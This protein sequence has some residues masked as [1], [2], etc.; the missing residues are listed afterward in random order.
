M[1]N[2]T[3]TQPTNQANQLERV[4]THKGRW[5]LIGLI[6][7]FLMPVALVIAMIKY[8]WRPSTISVE[9]QLITPPK[10]IQLDS[11][12]QTSDGKPFTKQVWQDHWTMLY[13]ADSCAAQCEARVKELR[14]IHVSLAQDIPRMQRV[15]VTAQAD[16][17]KLQANYPEMFILHQPMPAVESLL[18]Q[19]KVIN[20]QQDNFM[21]IVD[22]FGNAMMRYNDNIEAI[23]IR[24]DITRLLK[25][26]SAA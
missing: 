24:K 4:N 22:P 23:K 18:T 16:I 7:F 26:A 12:L 11:N 2:N 17:S 3:H 20:Q 25:F 9:G 5:V 8:D 14:Q 15:L 6:V 19:L 1:D 10:L 21:V 13:V